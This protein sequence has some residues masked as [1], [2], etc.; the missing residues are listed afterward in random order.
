LKVP[1]HSQGGLLTHLLGSK[2][3]NSIGLN[4]AYKNESL[5]NNETIIRSSVDVVSALSVP[6]KFA[7]SLLYPGWTKKHMITIPAK[8]SNPIEEHKID[9]LDRLD[10]EM[11]IG[12][13]KKIMG[14]CAC[15]LN[16]PSK[17]DLLLGK[18]KNKN[19]KV[20]WNSIQIQVPDQMFN[21]T[22]TGKLSIR[23]TLTSTKNPSKSEKFSSVQL[24]PANIDEPKIIN[25]GKKYNYEELQERLIKAKQLSLKYK[26]SDI[27]KKSAN[28]EDMSI[29]LKGY[30]IHLQKNVSNKKQ[31]A[32]QNEFKKLVNDIDKKIN[33]IETK[34][35][36]GEEV[37]KKLDIIEK[38]DEETKEIN[39]SM[40][41]EYEKELK[42]L[43]DI[44]PSIRN[45]DR[46][47][48]VQ[49]MIEQLK[50]QL[51]LIPQ[52]KGKKEIKYAPKRVYRPLQHK[53]WYN[54]QK[55]DE[56]PKIDL[57]VFKSKEFLTAAVDLYYRDKGQ[58]LTN[59]SKF[60]MTKLKQIIVKRNIPLSELVKFYN[61]AIDN[62]FNMYS[63]PDSDKSDKIKKLRKKWAQ[64]YINIKTEKNQ[65]RDEKQKRDEEYRDYIKKKEKG[66]EE[67]RN[68]IKKQ[69]KENPIWT[70]YA[71]EVKTKKGPIDFTF[72]R[73]FKYTTLET[74][75]GYK[76]I[77][78]NKE[79]MKTAV[80][81]TQYVSEYKDPK[82]YKW[83]KPYIYRTNENDY[84]FW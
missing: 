80:D 23:N 31:K 61:K 67:Y 63:D 69:E 35:L 29:K 38:Y 33:E 50:S 3:K 30:V 27:F 58:K 45:N 21:I 15:K 13:G 54:T 26:N 39:M 49:H 82:L 25:K 36:S 55:R 41:K 14:G 72:S 42:E 70:Q 51:G 60:N 40:L 57:D 16:D 4:P 84:L 52:P 78:N 74:K 19:N 12:K 9:I 47:L 75:D 22:K 32:I 73:D 43:D 2:S 56:E 66:E 77:F 53:L 71:L 59:L 18:G 10:P 24:I 48:Y 76:Y 64:Q 11:K 28:K 79:D 17:I 20:L 62:M 81:L 1:G 7:N 6:K 37:A 65:K 83:G 34:K 68:Y 44:K 5:A 46:L 8:T